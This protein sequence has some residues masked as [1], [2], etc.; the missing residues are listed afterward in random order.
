MVVELKLQQ[1]L[2]IIIIT[3]K[4]INYLNKKNKLELMKIN[5]TYN[6][7]THMEI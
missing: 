4:F 5:L 7:E 6:T 3:G 1:L 2:M